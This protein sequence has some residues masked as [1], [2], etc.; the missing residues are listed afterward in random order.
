MLVMDAET[1]DRRTDDTV[2][3][4]PDAGDTV[5][6]DPVSDDTV[7]IPVAPALPAP[8]SEPQPVT[9]RLRSPGLWGLRARILFWSIITLTLTVS[10]AVLAVRQVLFAQVDDRID[11]ALVQE[12]NELR[13]LTRGRDPQTG[14]RFGTDV[15]RIFEVFLQRNVPQRHETY[16]TFIGGEPFARSSQRPPYRLDRDEAFIARVGGLTETDRGSIDTPEGRVE[17]LAIPIVVNGAPNGVFVSAF[18]RDLEAEEVGP[19]TRAA[20]EVGLLT[21]LIGSLVAWRVAEGVLRPVRVTTETARQ[22]STADLTRRVPVSGR[23]ELAELGE[24]FNDLL[25]KLEEAFETQRRFVDDAGHELRTPITIVR[26]HLELLDDD[27]EDRQRTLD[28]VQDE[29]DRM[30]RIVTDLLTLAKAERPDFLSLDAV[31]LTELIGDL[32]EK[33]RTLGA[34]DWRIEPAGR[35]IVVADRQRL[36][37]AMIQLAQNAVEHTSEGAEIALGSV[38]TGDEAH[39]WV[40]D[41]GE[42]IAPEDLEEIFG[43]FSRAQRKRAS[44]GA[45]LGLSIVRAIAEAHGGR[46]AVAST[47]GEGST[48]TLIVPVDQ[49]DREEDGS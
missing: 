24:T 9:R 41:H 14:E 4:D 18:F 43:R 35:G 29:L 47:Q 21:L 19:A 37:Q 30:Q 23:D 22:I 26:G 42:G 11:E 48:F 6:L 40:R 44:E 34:R 8:P 25:S 17:Y 2:P 12:T 32:G 36:S 10:M 27:P 38:V 46:V 3:L 33:V 45:G 1:R 31:D 16:L 15:E 20:I 28:L 13:S 7:P 5:P 49:P 39:L